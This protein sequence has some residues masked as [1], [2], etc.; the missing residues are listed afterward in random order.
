ME[1]NEASLAEAAVSEMPSGPAYPFLW[2][3]SA[4]GHFT[5]EPRK[6]SLDRSVFFDTKQSK[7]KERNVF[8]VK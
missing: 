2:P 4:K 6:C 5:Q 3:N 7:G 8:E 1:P